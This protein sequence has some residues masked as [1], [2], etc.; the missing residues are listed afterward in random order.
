[1]RI[2]LDLGE[3]HKE[4]SEFRDCIVLADR[5]GF[6]TAWLGDHFLPWYHS[7]NQ[8]SYVW[9]VIGPSLE[10]TKKIKVGPLVTTPI[11]GRYHPAIVAQACA[12]LDNMYPGRLAVSIGSG[13]AMN[14]VPFLGE[15][16]GWQERAERLVEGT[17]FLREFWEKSS[18]FDF[19]GK[20]FQMKNVFLYTKPKTRLRIYFS[21]VG[22]KAA[23]MAGECG[24]DLLTLNSHN[25]I[26]RCKSVIFP[27]FESG[28]RSSKRNFSDFRKAV[29]LNFEVGPRDE[30]L[31]GARESAG[32]IAKG[33]LDEPDPR[34]I[35]EMG[36]KNVS[37]EEL[38]KHMQIFESW[39]RALDYVSKFQ[40]LGVDEVMLPSGPDPGTIN[41]MAEK[42]LPHFV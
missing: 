35:Q 21:A 40:E 6:D 39:E 23:K 5:L 20:Y 29:S 41:K 18:Y 34:K 38:E 10:I 24:E 17:R 1:M 15:W 27:A 12:T 7:G 3:N 13:E 33:A 4:P 2:S 32:I 14:E 26:D 16:P 37:D 9:S 25:S 19:E 11:G 31:K 36:Y 22:P 8:S 28:A 42:I 30:V